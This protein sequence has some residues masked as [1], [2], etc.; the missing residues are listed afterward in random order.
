[1][2]RHGHVSKRWTCSLCLSCDIA[3]HVFEGKARLVDV[4]GQILVHHILITEVAAIAL[5]MAHVWFVV[6]QIH[7]CAAFGGASVV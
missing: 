5:L 1:M 2:L 3:G 6:I 7:R 4:H